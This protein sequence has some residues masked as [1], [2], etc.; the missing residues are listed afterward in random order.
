[1]KKSVLYAAL[2]GIILFA[3]VGCTGNSNTQAGNTQETGQAQ[4]TG[5]VN[6]DKIKEK[7]ELVLATSADYPPFEWHLMKD[8]QDTIV[9]FDIAIAQEIAD[10]LGVK[11]VIKDLDFEAVIPALTT[12]QA[13]IA[14][15]GLVPTP[16]RE[17]VVNFSQPYFQNNQVVI[18]H[19]DNEAKYKKIE[20]FAGKKVGAQTGSTQETIANEQFPKDIEVLSLSKINNLI[21]EVKNKTADGLVIVDNSAKQYLV[22][23]TDLAIVDVGIPPE[24]G[25]CIAVG[26]D[27][28]DLAKFV[29]EK[30][31]KLMD[32]GKVESY[33]KEYEE[34]ASK[35]QVAE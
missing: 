33:I 34:L 11:L 8:G 4:A 2:L 18:V 22:Q 14:I 28:E 16:E 23:N 5:Q 32:E 3:L 7:G 19:K 25:T 9:G 35:E 26:K 15:A 13:D 12:G 10:E 30:L 17:E 20:D 31:Q 21:M 1:M 24:D 29:D 6:I 27:K